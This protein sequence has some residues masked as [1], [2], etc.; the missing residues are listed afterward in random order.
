MFFWNSL[1]SFLM[2]KAL[3]DV[4]YCSLYACMLSCFSCVP[5]DCS[6]PGSSFMGFSRQEHWSGLPYP[7]S[8]DL[9]NPGIE[10]KVLTSPA[11]AG[12]IFTASTTLEDLVLIMNYISIKL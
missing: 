1:N 2:F 8:V 5:V 6:P 11:L 4:N 9:L 12:E 3:S 10:R 7:P